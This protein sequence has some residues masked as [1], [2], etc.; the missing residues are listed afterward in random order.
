MVE[1]LRNEKKTLEEGYE[2]NVQEIEKEHKKDLEELNLAK[3]CI[4]EKALNFG[5]RLNDVSK[6]I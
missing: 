3:D 2:N 5:E 4:H 1:F 6:Q